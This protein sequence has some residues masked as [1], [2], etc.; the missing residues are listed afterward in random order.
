MKLVHKLFA[1]GMLAL[2]VQQISFAYEIYN[3][4]NDALDIFTDKNVFKIDAEGAGDVGEMLSNGLAIRKNVKPGQHVGWNQHHKQLKK[5]EDLFFVVT[6][7]K[8]KTQSKKNVNTYKISKRAA[9]HVTDGPDGT[10]NVMRCLENPNKKGDW[11][12]CAM[13]DKLIP[14]DGRYYGYYVVNDDVST[15]SPTESTVFLTF[16]DMLAKIPAEERKCME[17]LGE[18]FPGQRMYN[19]QTKECQTDKAL[20]LGCP[21]GSEYDELNGVRVLRCKSEAKAFEC[22]KALSS[23]YFNHSGQG[24]WNSTTNECQTPGALNGCPGGSEY[25]EVN[26]VKVL[27]CKGE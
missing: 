26:G 22:A 12:D 3:N 20:N 6:R 27:R 23:T 18:I 13:V 11:S 4:T 9:I 5:F 14:S 8:E 17:A 2:S 1:I 25:A 7:S 21:D 19:A 24:Y 10:F 15:T 16:T